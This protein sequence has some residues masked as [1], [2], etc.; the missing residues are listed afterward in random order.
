MEPEELIKKIESIVNE[1]E[2]SA[3]ELR[4]EVERLEGEL[5]TFNDPA[6]TR[7]MRHRDVKPDEYPAVLPVPRLQLEF[8]DTG[9][10]SAEYR[11]E[12]IYKHYA[13]DRL[14]A[15]PF[16]LTTTN[17]GPQS[18]KEPFPEPFRES[19]H[20]RF[21]ADNMKLPAFV[22]RDGKFRK[23]GTHSEFRNDGKLYAD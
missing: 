13:D 6:K 16:G 21:D 15:V 5:A 22:V 10:Y 17:G 18:F 12:L 20:I 14:I 19:H 1:E 3:S 23:L 9:D 8:V 7:W 4:D 11:Y 2:Q